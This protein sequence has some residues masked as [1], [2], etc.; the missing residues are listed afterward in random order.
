MAD[1]PVDIFPPLSA[2]E[3]LAFQF[4]AWYPTF[5]ALSV[6]STVV[7]P[8]PAAFRAYLDADGVFI[9]RGSDD[10]FVRAVGV[11]YALRSRGLTVGI[12]ILSLHALHT[13]PCIHIW[14]TMHADKTDLQSV[15][16]RMRTTRRVAMTK[17]KMR[18]SHMRSR[19]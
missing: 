1:A 19:T 13:F 11:V 10:V 4:S 7:R 3:V 16:S 9:P 15:R 2:S 17:T 14:C 5:A 6:K 18:A 12:P 8:L